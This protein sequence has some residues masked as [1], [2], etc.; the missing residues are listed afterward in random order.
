MQPLWELTLAR[1]WHWGIAILGAPGA[2]LPEELGPGV[3]TANRDTLVIKVKHAQDISAEVF[4]GEW[5][6]AIATVRVRCIP[7]VEDAGERPEFEGS[8]ILPG[9]RL[10]I[11]DAD[12][13]ITVDDLDTRTT[14]K[15]F[16]EAPSDAGASE[17]RID[18]AP[19]S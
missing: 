11:G 7:S 13:H 6:W 4:E 12:S 10:E 14:V 18:L 17:V 19:A 16:V 2:A 1:P 15:I 9:G 3:V 5:D 8:L